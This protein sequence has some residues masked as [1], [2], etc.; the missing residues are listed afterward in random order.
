MIKYKKLVRDKI[1]DIIKANGGECK[2][3]VAKKDEFSALL[4]QKLLEE[5]DELIENPCAEEIG[6]VLEVVEAIARLNGIS[7]DEIKAEKLEKRTKRGGFY[8]RI[9]LDEATEPL[10]RDG[11]HVHIKTGSKKLLKNFKTSGTK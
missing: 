4:A 7:L 11:S 8:K 6:D 9:V 1:P 5:V 3:H 2:F 10:E